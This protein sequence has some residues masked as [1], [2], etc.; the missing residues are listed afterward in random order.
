MRKWGGLLLLAV[1]IPVTQLR[2]QIPKDSLFDAVVQQ[3]IGH[4]Y[5]LEFEKAEQE[6]TTL[7]ALRPRHPAGWFF[8]AMVIWWKI[9]IDVENPRYDDQFFAALDGVVDMC[10][11]ILEVNRDDLDAMFFKGGA[12]GFEGRL[13]FHR[14]DWLG[15]ANAGRKALPLVQRASELDPENYDIYLGT[16]IYNYYAEVI[17]NEYPVVKPLMLFVPPGDKKKGLEQLT[18]AAEKGRYAAV[19]TMYFLAQIYYNYEKDYPRALRLSLDLHNRF[20]DNMV[21]H[22]YVG[23]CHV[24]M[25]NWERAD[26]V[27]REILERVNA[28]QRGY[29][30]VIEREALYYLGMSAM[31][32]RR[33]DEALHYFYRCDAVSRLLDTREPSGFMVMVNLKIGMTYDLQGKRDLAVSQ[34]EKVRSMKEYKDSRVQAERYLQ[35]PYP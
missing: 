25:S 19:E 13:K 26:A 20:P 17:P 15:A 7:I 21:F 1:L 18:V 4:V 10:D 9:M 6:F 2:A 8:R 29:T 33:L 5:N 23:R 22:K 30:P 27:F 11:S 3:G 12:I 16:G 14:D 35:T 28:G 31:N 34:Y 32:T 24:V